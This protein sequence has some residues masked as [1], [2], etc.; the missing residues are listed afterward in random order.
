MVVETIATLQRSQPET[1]RDR[2]RK[3]GILDL[4]R[5]IEELADRLHAALVGREIQQPEKD[6][7]VQEIDLPINYIGCRPRFSQESMRQLKNEG[8]TR[9]SE[10]AMLRVTDS[11]GLISVLKDRF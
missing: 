9:V 10:L 5:L 11:A 7:E 3:L 8:F 2:F 1:S 6:W 4:E